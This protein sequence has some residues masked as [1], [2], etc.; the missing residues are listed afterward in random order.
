MRRLLTTTMLGLV[1]LLCSG[2]SCMDKGTTTNLLLSNAGRF[3]KDPVSES[4]FYSRDFPGIRNPFAAGGVDTHF[5]IYARKKVN[6]GNLWEHNLNFFGLRCWDDGAGFSPTEI[7]D[8]VWSVPGDGR[9]RI[10]VR[11]FL[12]S[13]GFTSPTPSDI[14]CRWRVGGRLDLGGKAE[15]K[16]ARKTFLGGGEPYPFTAG[17]KSAVALAIVVVDASG[18]ILSQTWT[19]TP[20]FAQDAF[21]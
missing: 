17:I 18:N 12:T 2:S 4:T 3:R 15:L 19:D 1:A 10:G 20:V 14:R 11:D 13:E 8:R 21:D 5:D 9:Y 7:G 6:L 16:A